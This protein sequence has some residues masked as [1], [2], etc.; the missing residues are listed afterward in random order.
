MEEQRPHHHLRPHAPPERKGQ[1]RKLEVVKHEDE[2][3]DDRDDDDDADP[4]PLAASRAAP[5]TEP[6]HALIS[7]IRSQVD[8]L[9]STFSWADSDRSAAKCATHVLAE[10]AKNGNPPFPI[11]AEAVG[12][13]VLFYSVRVYFYVYFLFC[14]RGD[15]ECGCGVRRG[16]GA[17]EAPSCAAGWKREGRGGEAVRARG[18]K[19]QRLCFGSSCGEGAFGYSIHQFLW[20]SQVNP[21]VQLFMLRFRI[22][23]EVVCIAFIFSSLK[24][25]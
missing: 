17:G 11:G 5:S 19:G 18:R 23:V 14:F 1:K 22:R 20:L 9:H 4:P 12:V 8:L 13:V 24:C 16:A 15:C 7:Q 21:L 25:V 10:L 3:D 6:H 2:E